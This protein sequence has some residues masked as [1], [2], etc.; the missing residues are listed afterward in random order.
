MRLVVI[1]ARAAKAYFGAKA[2]AAALLIIRTRFDMR[3]AW[4][5]RLKAVEHHRITMRKL[6]MARHHESEAKERWEHSQEVKSKADSKFHAAE[7][8]HHKAHKA[9]E[10]AEEIDNATDQLR[11]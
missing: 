9:H 2:R 6:H 3:L 5:A 8:A 1:R 10:A 11:D 4:D 7:R